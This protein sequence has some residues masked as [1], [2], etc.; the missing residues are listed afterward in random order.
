MGVVGEEEEEEEELPWTELDEVALKLGAKI[1]I[2]PPIPLDL[3]KS[4]FAFFA[5]KQKEKANRKKKE[6]KYPDRFLSLI[7]DPTNYLEIFFYLIAFFAR[8]PL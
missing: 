6:K 5:W 7:Q 1:T 2:G 3:L 4:K 8:T